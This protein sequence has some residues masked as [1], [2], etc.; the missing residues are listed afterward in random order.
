LPAAAPTVAAVP[1]PR[2]FRIVPAVGLGMASMKFRKA[3]KP[4]VASIQDR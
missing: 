1:E 2:L 3:K 4:V